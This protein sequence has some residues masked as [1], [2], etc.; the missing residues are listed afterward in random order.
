[1]L[2]FLGILASLLSLAM[3]A[4]LAAGAGEEVGVPAGAA[5]T[6]FDFEHG[7]LDGWTTVD[8]QWAVE[9]AADAP[10]GARVLVQRATRN[11][12]NVIVAPGGPWTDVDVSVRF[13]PISGREDASGGIVF[14]FADGRRYYLVRERARG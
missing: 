3:P 1:M 8:G 12:F 11:A 10:S 7:A 2:T 13:K 6:R 4:S 5:V 9:E 14:R